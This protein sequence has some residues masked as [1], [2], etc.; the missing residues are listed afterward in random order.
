MKVMSRVTRYY[1]P[2]L[3]DDG[4]ITSESIVTEDILI[5]ER[6]EIA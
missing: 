5:E 6:K 4:I 1:F 3:Q 2:S